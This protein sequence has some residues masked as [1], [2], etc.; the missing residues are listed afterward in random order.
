MN[1]EALEKS[2]AS[3][4]GRNRV[5]YKDTLG[6]WTV[7]IGH[8]CEKPFSD[9][10][11]DQLFQEDIGESISELDRAFPTWRDH[12]DARQ[13]VLAEMMYNLG[14]ARFAGFVRFW[15]AM[16]VRDYA[17][18]SQEMLQSNW[19]LQVGQRANT[20]AK[21]LLDDTLE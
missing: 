14:A 6:V 13:N 12:S 15:A 4:E 1:L 18:A 5:M 8:N 17:G 9:K 10:V 19:H 2:L 21:R 20:L 3:H 11:I 7:G 16:R